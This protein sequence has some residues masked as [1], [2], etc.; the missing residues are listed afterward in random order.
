M[1]LVFFSHPDSNNQ[2][3]FFAHDL[4]GQFSYKLRSIL[5]YFVDLQEY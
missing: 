1:L 3:A 5:R 4:S 2:A